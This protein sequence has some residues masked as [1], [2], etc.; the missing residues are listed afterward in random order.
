MAARVGLVR[1]A[2][3]PLY[4]TDDLLV[5]LRQDERVQVD[6][7][8]VGADPTRAVDAL[9][10]LG[11]PGARCGYDV[12][13]GPALDNP[14]RWEVYASPSPGQTRPGRVVDSLLGDVTLD[15]I[16]A[17]RGHR[18]HYR[19]QWG[20]G[21]RSLVLVLCDQ[22]PASLLAHQPD[23][24]Q[25]LLGQLPVDEYQVVVALHPGLWHTWGPTAMAG[26]ARELLRAGALLLPAEAG[27]QA[28]IVAA[29]HVIGDQGPMSAYAHRMGRHT[30]TAVPTPQRPGPALGVLHVREAVHAQLAADAT[31]PNAHLFE[32]AHRRRSMPAQWGGEA[33]LTGLYA[34][35]GL[36]PDPA[37]PL[38]APAGVAGI[39]HTDPDRIIRARIP[40]VVSAEG[41]D[42]EV[43]LRR[44]PLA[45]PPPD[46]H[47][48][49]VVIDVAEPHSRYREMADLVLCPP[50]PGADPWRVLDATIDAFAHP[51]LGSG[52]LVAVL[53]QDG[54]LLGLA[55]TSRYRLCAVH[56][57]AAMD[58]ALLACAF[59]AVRRYAHQR[60]HA[61][62]K[63]LTLLVRAGHQCVPVRITPVST[64]A[65]T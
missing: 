40:L 23:L 35:L 22:G 7:L 33:V 15:R 42:R 48:P 38:V 50:T 12:V 63:E 18:E 37:L 43:V 3:I 17:G 9:P 11:W 65:H 34:H 49:I 13:L 51:G 1:R 28:A 27:W 2:G 41:D 59:W 45:A 4:R 62:T 36:D 54:C 57:G 52:P 61:L 29:D 32:H 46:L 39:A 14:V 6:I 60:A 21:Q 26:W 19:R 58:P 64:R 20:T 47:R 8:T 10:T 24:P 5:R 55:D 53:H 16:R 30:M 56:S 31:R 25:Q 44:W